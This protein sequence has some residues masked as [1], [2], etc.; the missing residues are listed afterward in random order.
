MGGVHLQ[1]H[2]EGLEYAPRCALSLEVLGQVI[3][4][5]RKGSVLAQDMVLRA[6]TA[7]GTRE[8]C[9]RK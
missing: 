1:A 4:L 7:L 2:L 5:R 9:T 8:E 3:E 6:G